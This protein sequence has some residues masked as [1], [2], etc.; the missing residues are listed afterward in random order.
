MYLNKD[1]V[2]GRM[3]IEKMLNL[4]FS[5]TASYHEIALELLNWIKDKVAEEGRSEPWVT[6]SE[7]SRFIN[8]R[9]GKRR[10]STAYKVIREYLMPM[11]ILSLDFDKGQYTISKEFSRT[12]RRL[13]DAYDS[14]LKS[15]RGVEV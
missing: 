7:L 11:G 10:R 1:E 14:W 12:L 9:F 15:Q 13:A 4:M 2:K 8:D 5:S 3:S 6:R